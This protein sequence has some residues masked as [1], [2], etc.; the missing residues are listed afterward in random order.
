VAVD[1]SG[2][3]RWGNRRQAD[4]ARAL[5]AAGRVACQEI[6][7][8]VVHFEEAAEAGREYVGEHPERSVRL[9]VTFD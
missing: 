5:L 7:W 1:H 4:A 8:P 9:G 3:P 6:V 2:H